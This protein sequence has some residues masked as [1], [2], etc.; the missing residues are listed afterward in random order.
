MDKMLRDQQHSQPASQTEDSLGAQAQG[1]GTVAK[2]APK[3]LRLG[4]P[5]CSSFPLYFIIPIVII[6]GLCPLP[7]QSLRAGTAD[8]RTPSDT[9]YPHLLPSHFFQKW[10]TKAFGNSIPYI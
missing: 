6:I 1:A 9:S 4:Q 8:V 10:S 3:R 7:L 5:N 2:E